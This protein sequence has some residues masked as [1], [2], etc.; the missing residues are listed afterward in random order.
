MRVG[1][2]KDNNAEV[3]ISHLD[4]FLPCKDRQ[5]QQTRLTVAWVKLLIRALACYREEYVYIK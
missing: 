3:L 4:G 1:K 2:Q 5:E